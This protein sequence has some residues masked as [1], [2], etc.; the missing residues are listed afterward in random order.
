MLAPATLESVMELAADAGR[1][2]DTARTKLGIG[3]DVATATATTEA[4][5]EAVSAFQFPDDVWSRV[6]YDLA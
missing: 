1:I 3:E 4:M 2:G 5:A 6:I